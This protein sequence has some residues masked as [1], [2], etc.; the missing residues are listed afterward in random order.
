MGFSGQEV[1]SGMPFPS[2]GNLPN[3][4]NEP[5][6]P[7]SPALAGGFFTTVPPGTLGPLEKYILILQV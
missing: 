3:A 1:W 5:K 2:P 7:P 6:P 4:G